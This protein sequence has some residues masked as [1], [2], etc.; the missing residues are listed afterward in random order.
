MP[1]VLSFSTLQR[2]IQSEPA[3]KLRS[4]TEIGVYNKSIDFKGLKGTIKDTISQPQRFRGSKL[5]WKSTIKVKITD[6][7]KFDG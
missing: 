6:L 7:L 1:I 5:V 4:E 3:V 2:D